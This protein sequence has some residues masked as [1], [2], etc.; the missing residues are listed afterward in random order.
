MQH[1][2]RSNFAPSLSCCRPKEEF[3]EWGNRGMLI[4]FSKQKVE[5]SLVKKLLKKKQKTIYFPSDINNRIIGPIYHC[6]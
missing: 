3:V 4:L 5:I 1:H 6:D 2:F